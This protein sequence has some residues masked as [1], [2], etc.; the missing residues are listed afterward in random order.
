MRRGDLEDNYKA[1]S[2]P[3]IEVWE[4]PNGVLY[5]HDIKDG[6]LLILRRMK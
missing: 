2:V 6:P 3:G 1:E 4:K 5:V